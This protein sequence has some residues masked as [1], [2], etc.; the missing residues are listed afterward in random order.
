[1]EQEE[2]GIAAINVSA[3]TDSEAIIEDEVFR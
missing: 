1:V 3:A 2:A